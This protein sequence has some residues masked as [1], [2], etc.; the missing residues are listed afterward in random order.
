[1]K[2]LNDK[3]GNLT[4]VVNGTTPSSEVKAYWNGSFTWITPTDLGKM[5]DIYIN[6]SIRKITKEGI[7]SCSLTLVPKN[8]VVM[9]S[10]A[11]IGYLGIA[12][13]DLYTNQGC[14]SFICG[15][16]INHLFLYYNL[17]Y[18]MKEIQDL[19]SGSTFI[20]IS[21]SAIENFEISY[22]ELESDQ[23]KIA[24]QLKLQFDKIKET[25]TSIDFLKKELEILPGKFLKS[26]F[27]QI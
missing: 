10:R 5:E 3:L 7:K 24:A 13:V 12:N 16:Q 27:E 25:R 1:M 17:M 8:S 26:A 9:S 14:K 18:R 6:S 22:P 20:E 21:K 23:L 11:P 4:E 19:G 15:P 2:W